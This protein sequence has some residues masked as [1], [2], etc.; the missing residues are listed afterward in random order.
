[1]HPAIKYTFGKAEV[2]VK[3]SESCQVIN[4][5]DVSVI[6]NLDRNIETDI[7]YKDTNTHD[8]LPYNSAY[9]DHSR[10]NIPYNLAKLIIVFVSNEEKIEY[11]LNELKNSL[12]SC[13]YPEIV[14]NRAFRNVK[15]QG[16]EPL[17][18]IQIIFY[19]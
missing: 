16:P 17:K 4:F 2:I 1:M 15:L 12:Q 7:Y 14:I 8:Y 10:D 11:R 9:L 5:L 13:K 6:L 18:K 3:N 19:L